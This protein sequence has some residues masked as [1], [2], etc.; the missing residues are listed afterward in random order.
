M[1]L[2]KYNY[3]FFT[4]LFLDILKNN[5]LAEETQGVPLKL[6]QGQVQFVMKPVSVISDSFILVLNKK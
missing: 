4:Q 5:W 2:C 6:L 1:R 3:I